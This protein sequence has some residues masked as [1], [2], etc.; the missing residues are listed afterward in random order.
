MNVTAV[1]VVG[2]PR[3]GVDVLAPLHGVPMLVRAVR[4]VLG[5]GLVG[6]VALLDVDARPDALLR[7]CSGLPVSVHDEFRHAVIPVPTHAGQRADTTIGDGSV[8]SASGDVVLLHDAARPL[9]PSA[10]AAAVVEAVRSGHDIAVPVLPLADTVKQVDEDGVV[11]GTPDRA[12][13]RVVQAPHAIRRE[14]LDPDLAVD[15]LGVALAHAAAGGAVH[16]V[17]GD[18][19]AFAVRTAWDLEVAELLV[20]R[21]VER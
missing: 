8:T 13:L 20:G 16:A 10:L 1:I 2:G 21:E 12:G 11:R 6:H 19:A 3:A 4:S 7:A 15:P 17:P 14:L 9:A 18:P 5:T